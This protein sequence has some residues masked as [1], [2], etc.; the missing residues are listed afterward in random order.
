M[1]YPPV[2]R[3]LLKLKRTQ[4]TRC[5]NGA[6]GEGAEGEFWLTEL[7]S[8]LSPLEGEGDAPAGNIEPTMRAVAAR[9]A[10]T[11]LE[12]KSGGDSGGPFI[13]GTND[14]PVLVGIVSFGAGN[15]R[16]SMQTGQAAPTV[17]TQV[18]NESI[19]KFVIGHL[20]EAG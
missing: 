1:K 3:Y 17:F 2:R 4:H 5:A 8:D 16:R 18:A 11:L 6:Q 19:R 9:S 15:C 12:P 10:A 14:E 13:C 20:R 7:P